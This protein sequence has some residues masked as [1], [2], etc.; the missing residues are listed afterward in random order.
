MRLKVLKVTIFFFFFILFFDIFRMQILLGPK[1]EKQSENNRIRLVPEE[2]TRG[3]IYDRNNIPLVENKLAFDVVA[4]PQEINKENEQDLF[5]KLS[6]F[7]GIDSQLLADAFVENFNS[8]FS[9]VMLASGVSRDTAFLIEQE[10]A[11]VP[12][13]FVKTRAVRNYIYGEAASHLT[14]YVGKMREN[15]YP[16]LKKYG[17]Q[18]KDVIGRSGLEESCDQELRGKPGGMQLEVNS[19]GKIIKVISYRP[20]MAGEDIFTTIDLKL[21]QLL[22]TLLK[23]EKGAVCVMDARTGEMLALCSAPAY[24]AN[25]LIDKKK[26]RKISKIFKDPD[27]PLLNRALNT[28]APGSIFKIVTAY[29]AMD[30]G[31]VSPEDT[32]ECRGEYTIGNST[33]HCWLRRGHG[34]VNLRQAIATSCNVFFWHIGYKTGEKNISAAAREFGLGRITGIDLPGEQPGAVPDSHWKKQV[35]HKKWYGGD[36]INFAIGQGYLLVSPIQAVKLVAMVANGGKEV[37][38]HI[39]KRRLHP[40][41]KVLDEHILEAIRGG[42]YDVVNDISGTGRKAFVSGVKIYGKTGTA[43]VSGQRAHAWFVAYFQLKGRLVSFA[44]FLEHG[45]HGG[46]GPAEIAREIVLYFNS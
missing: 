37:T 31:H 14:G 10:M 44:V 15:E 24:D 20:P 45:G 36:T 22:T 34:F 11:Q 12:G 41:K 18:I 13:A 1:Y 33:R 28:Y 6:D 27:A 38:P 39:V 4:I 26:F 2:A 29:A 30:K 17:Y 7:L 8:S 46:E 23:G 40:G 5:G 32:F 42:M 21:Q 9:P 35:L 16:K 43:Q 19:E 3:I 25:I